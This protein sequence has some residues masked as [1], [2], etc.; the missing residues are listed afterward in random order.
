MHSHGG[1]FIP[2]IVNCSIRRNRAESR[3]GGVSSFISSPKMVK[4]HVRGQFG[5]RFGRGLVFAD[6]NYGPTA[7]NCIFWGNSAD[8]SG[9]QIGIHDCTLRISHSDVQGGLEGMR[10]SG[11]GDVLWG[12]GNIDADP[13]FEDAGEGNYYVS[14]GSPCVDAGDNSAVPAWVVTDLFGKPRILGQAVDM[15]CCE[16]EGPR[17][18]YV[19][20][21]ARGADD[22][23]SWEDAF[24]YLQDGLAAA[25][26]GDEIRVAAGVY[27]PD[28]GA[29]GEQGGSDG[30]SSG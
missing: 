21:D 28:R 2:L 6:D 1:G 20:D 17:V 11:D 29:L 23:S 4:L 14:A 15:G 8:E 24:R 30:D 13:L 19:D 7:V 12:E 16:S 10:I 18:I 9:L 22:G 5:R 3:G 25:S 27:R 26:A